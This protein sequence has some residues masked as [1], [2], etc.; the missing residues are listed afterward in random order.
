[1]E[2]EEVLRRR[3]MVRRFTDAPIDPADRD[4]LLAAALRGP[5]AGFAQGFGFLVLEDETDRA[6]L[7]E[8]NPQPVAEP[9]DD[10][11]VRRAPLIIV[12][13]A[14][15]QAYI[16]RY[17]E[18]DKEGPG[19]DPT[20]RVPVWIIDTAFASMLILLRVVDLGLGAVF[21]APPVDLPGFRARFGVPDDYLPIG[22]ILVG[23]RPPHPGAGA[24]RAR[25]KAPDSQVF[26][27]RWGAAPAA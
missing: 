14:S 22:M 5:S 11:T 17:R 25:R 20:W 1:M 7:W 23:H 10:A 27:G 6:L 9:D 12:P 21:G 19:S 4:Q 16:N 8:T 26:L 15:H 3:R 24:P 13:L 2:L 18:P